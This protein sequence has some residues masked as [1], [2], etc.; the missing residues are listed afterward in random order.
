MRKSVFSEGVIHGSFLATAS[1]RLFPFH[2]T[3]GGKIG[4]VAASEN[5]GVGVAAVGGSAI[6]VE[7]IAMQSATII[8]RSLINFTYDF[9]SRR[10]RSCSRATDVSIP[11]RNPRMSRHRWTRR[12]SMRPSYSMT[13]KVIPGFSLSES[14]MLLG[15]TIS[16]SF[17]SFVSTSER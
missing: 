15:S 5:V 16:N 1:A 7:I 12:S 11:R 17:E 10:E 4:W 8:N 13:L 14:H 3:T 2:G 6:A 9:F